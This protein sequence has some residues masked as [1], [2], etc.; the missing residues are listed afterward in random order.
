MEA[1][2]KGI[3]CPN[4]GRLERGNTTREKLKFCGLCVQ[5]MLRKFAREKNEKRGN[6]NRSNLPQDETSRGG[7]L[8]LPS[9]SAGG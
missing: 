1:E 6:P 8:P 4:C 9:I 7:V 5:D 3:T 2:N